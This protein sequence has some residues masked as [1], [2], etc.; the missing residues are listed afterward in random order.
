MKAQKILL[1]A[2]IG[3]AVAI[4]V[5]IVPACVPEMAVVE[6]PTLTID[7]DPTRYNDW[8][9]SPSAW[10]CSESDTGSPSAWGSGELIVDLPRSYGKPSKPSGASLE[11]LRALR[12]NINRAERAKEAAAGSE[13]SPKPKDSDDHHP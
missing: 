12:E 4:C 6:P 11:E 7:E 13:R 1:P 3:A 2:L 9:G 10:T 8:L 5:V